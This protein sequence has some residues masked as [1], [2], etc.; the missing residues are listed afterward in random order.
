MRDRARPDRGARDLIEFA[1]PLEFRLAQCLAYQLRGLGKAGPRLAHRDAEARVFDARGTPAKAEQAAPAAEN[2]E[3]CDLLGD[4]DRI[5]PWQ[6]DDRG[7]ED[8]PLGAP[9]EISQQLERC[10]RHR[11]TGEVV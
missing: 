7:P 10:R 8:D 6:D 11:I 1:V 2:V 9:G 5:V 3:E 4:A